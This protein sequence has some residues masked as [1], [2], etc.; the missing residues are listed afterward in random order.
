M[1][2]VIGTVV[3]IVGTVVTTYLA[4][5]NRPAPYRLADWAQSANSV[6]DS[7]RAQLGNDFS[8]VDNATQEALT[9][10]PPDIEAAARQMEAAPDYYAVIIGGLRA[11]RVPDERRADIEAAFRS[12]EELT[13]RYY[14]LA[15]L[16]RQLNPDDVTAEPLRTQLSD[17][18]DAVDQQWSALA[19]AW[20]SLGA[21]S[22]AIVPQ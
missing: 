12:A 16:I 11:I 18:F 3:A 20:R 14:A 15:D 1:L 10:Q 21:T 17:A 5:H 6:C 7:K 13:R 19:D 9:Q 22:C 8:Q 2:T 4:L